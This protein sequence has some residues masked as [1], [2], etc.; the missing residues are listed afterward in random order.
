MKLN[1]IGANIQY[2]YDVPTITT[3]THPG[4]WTLIG[5]GERVMEDLT[6]KDGSRKN[7]FELDCGSARE[8]EK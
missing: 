3:D 5:A 1:Q 6:D 4:L 2:P 7:N 8:D